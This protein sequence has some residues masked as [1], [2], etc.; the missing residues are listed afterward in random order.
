M[1]TDSKHARRIAAGKVSTLYI[2][3]RK[4]KAGAP[5]APIPFKE[6]HDYPVS[7]NG[8]DP[9][10]EVR[11]KAILKPAPLAITLLQARA[12][13]FR[14]T[15]DFKEWWIVTHDRAW[16][17]RERFDLIRSQEV[18]DELGVEFADF[19]RDAFL[20]RF[21]QRHALRLVWT[22]CIS[23]THDTPR[24]MAQQRGAGVG[25]G[26]YTRVPAK[27]IDPEAEVIPAQY[28][29]KLSKDALGF[30]LGRQ[31]KR[32]QEQAEAKARQR[33]ESKK[34]R[35]EMFRREAA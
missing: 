25:D 30:C 3:A 28:Q 12:A 26:Q 10:C 6:A 13:G 2:P 5:Y 31:R 21:D 24:F 27:S 32:Q 33:S 11:V 34:P 15:T 7:A 4:G 29:E 18:A 9:L 17:R 14:T 8:R 23:L 35:L 16:L 22:V 1:N 20:E 19:V